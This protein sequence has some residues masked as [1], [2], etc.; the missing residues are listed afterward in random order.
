VAGRIDWNTVV[1][2]YNSGLTTQEIGERIERRP[3]SVW[4]GLNQRGLLRKPLTK[5]NWGEALS[6]LNRGC[7]PKEIA[8]AFNVHLSW[9]Q[10]GLKRHGWEHNSRRKQIQADVLVDFAKG[11]TT[12]Q[13]GQKYQV[14]PSYIRLILRESGVNLHQVKQ[15]QDVPDSTNAFTA[16][17]LDADGTIGIYTR[18]KYYQLHVSVSNTD[19][20]LITWLKTS[21]GLGSISQRIHRRQEWRPLYTWSL[22]DNEALQVLQAVGPFLKEK[23][24]QAEVGIEF[25][26]NRKSRK[27]RDEAQRFSTKIKEL[28]QARYKY[29]LPIVKWAVPKQQEISIPES[30]LAYFAGF[31]DGEGTIAIRSRSCQGT[32]GSLRLGVINT[33]IPVIK[34][35]S[36]DFGF[37]S[38]IL[39]RDENKKP[40]ATWEVSGAD[41][42]NLLQLLLPFLIVKK[43]QAELALAF[44]KQLTEKLL[45]PGNITSYIERSKHLKRPTL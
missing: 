5:I 8:T 31:F 11:S 34:K 4:V 35:F 17:I 14:D 44:H 37:G 18:G 29:T 39:R 20:A 38:I 3:S 19:K 42:V 2:L 10:K 12:K 23:Q 9:V 28:N 40:T 1:Q 15:R 32:S 41:A 21:Y 45:T 24:A 26:S 27:T 7:T 16:G 13:I 6:M 33:Y 22:S 36:S 43:S 25:Q 30:D